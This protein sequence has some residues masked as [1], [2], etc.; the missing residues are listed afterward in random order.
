MKIS[1][2]PRQILPYAE[3][4][5]FIVIKV[6]E[7]TWWQTGEVFNK[8]VD[9]NGVNITVRGIQAFHQTGKTE[10]TSLYKYFNY[11]IKPVTTSATSEIS[12]ANLHHKLNSEALTKKGVKI[13]VAF[14]KFHICSIWFQ[15]L[16]VHTAR[17][18]ITFFSTK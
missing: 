14:L 13:T 3:H 8:I 6:W 2:S 15:F 10:Q 17:E 16:W 12:R 1:S 5:Y 7:N 18:I 9:I 4:K 11:S